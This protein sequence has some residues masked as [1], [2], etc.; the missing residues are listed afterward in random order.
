VLQIPRRTA[1]NSLIAAANAIRNG[2]AVVAGPNFVIRAAPGV[3]PYHQ[4]A[5]CVANA[6]TWHGGAEIAVITPSKAGGFAVGVVDRVRVGP[7]GQQ[8]NGPYDIRWEVADEEIANVHAANLDLP[9]DGALEATVQ[10]LNIVGGHPAVLMCRDWVLR[11]NRLTGQSSFDPA[12]VHEQLAL[13]F[14][15]HRR[16][17]RQ[18]AVRLK[19][20]TVHQAKNR[21]FEGVIVLWPYR[22]AGDSEQQRRLLYNAITRAQRW[23]TVVVQ[24]ANMLQRPPFAASP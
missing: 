13:C 9:A 7:V 24:N 3:A 8:Q 10:A 11:T 6:I 19:A 14:K 21:E 17:A 2:Q 18:D 12:L 22:V 5:A 4:A 16:F 23:C 20:M 1:Q 15:R